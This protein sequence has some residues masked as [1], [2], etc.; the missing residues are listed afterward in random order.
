M[1]L[2]PCFHLGEG[3][4]VD[5][6]PSRDG[7]A[8]EVRYQ[9]DVSEEELAFLAPDLALC[10]EDAAQQG[11]ALRDVSKGR[12]YIAYKGSQSRSLPNDLPPCL[13]TD[14]AM[15]GHGVFQDHCVGSA[16]FP[17]RI[18]PRRASLPRLRQP[19]AR[20]DCP[21]TR[22]KLITG[23]SGSPVFTRIH[24]RRHDWSVHIYSARNS[25]RDSNDRKMRSCK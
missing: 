10:R 2:F 16:Y 13:P 9:S 17:A 20:P 24:H 18:S 23:S 5:R 7:K 14:A 8:I 6:Y 1:T 4:R 3:I 19:D 22:T 21:A 25:A 12:R 15:D 11:H